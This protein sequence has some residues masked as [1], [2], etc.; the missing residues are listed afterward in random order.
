MIFKNFMSIRFFCKTK[1]NPAQTESGDKSPHS[2]RAYWVL[3]PKGAALHSPGRSPGCGCYVDVSPERAA[4]FIPGQRPGETRTPGALPRDKKS[5]PFRACNFYHTLP[6]A[7]PRAVKSRPLGAQ[8][9]FRPKTTLFSNSSHP[10]RR[11]VAA[12]LKVNP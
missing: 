12:L 7:L 3:S 1:K 10:K 5:R 11:H 4:L 6:R 9:P 2:I 8:K